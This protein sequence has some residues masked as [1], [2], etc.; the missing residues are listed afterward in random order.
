L[1]KALLTKEID[2]LAGQLNTGSERAS[3]LHAVEPW[4]PVHKPALVPARIDSDVR[5]IF[6]E[7]I[8]A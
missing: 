3:V 8:A 1:Y 5:A 2:Y 6:L 4:P 7:K